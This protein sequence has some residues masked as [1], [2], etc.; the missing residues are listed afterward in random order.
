MKTLLISAVFAILLASTVSAEGLTFSVR[1]GL[2][3]QGASI[4]KD[5]GNWTPLVGADVL[6]ISASYESGHTDVY[7]S[8][9]TGPD[10]YSSHYIYDK[11]TSGHAFLLIPHLGAKYHFRR[12]TA[13]KPVGFYARGTWYFSIPSVNA[14]DEETNESWVY[15]NG[16][17]VSH[18]RETVSSDMNG[19]EKDA[20][21]SLLSFWGLDVA[22][23]AEYSF[24]HGFSVGGEYGF[25][26][27]HDTAK[28]SHTQNDSWSGPEDDSEHI[29][30]WNRELRVAIRVTYAAISLNYKF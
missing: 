13:E 4:G 27:L 11:K 25:R 26:Y 8:H 23:G 21:N 10:T 14:K 28:E 20:I 24:G 22:F 5:F 2:I 18:D 17:F 15:Q 3:M 19:D 29:E 16:S 6:W 30:T 9:S 12:A 7:N 1:P